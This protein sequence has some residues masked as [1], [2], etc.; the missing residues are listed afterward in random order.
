MNVE[1][2]VMLEKTSLGF[3]IDGKEEKLLQEVVKEDI[4]SE[5]ENPKTVKERHAKHK[6]RDITASHFT[7]LFSGKQK[8]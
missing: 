4:L 7:R 5:N 1:E 3:Y 8:K 2:C 6:K